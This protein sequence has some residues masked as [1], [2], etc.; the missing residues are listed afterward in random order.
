M[1]SRPKQDA[2]EYQKPLDNTAAEGGEGPP[3]NGN[4]RDRDGALVQTPV[5]V[6]PETRRGTIVADMSGNTLPT[7][8]RRGEGKKKTRA[9]ED[10]EDDA[11]DQDIQDNL[12]AIRKAAAA[13]QMTMKEMGVDMEKKT[14]YNEISTSST[15][16]KEPP[17]HQNVRNESTTESRKNNVPPEAPQSEQGDVTNSSSDTSQHQENRTEGKPKHNTKKKRKSNKRSRKKAEP[18]N[19]SWTEREGTTRRSCNNQRK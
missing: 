6:T 3:L 11:E 10:M 9:T 5:A 19:S 17:N 16:S 18:H 1:P 7:T 13:A 4:K 15:K 14:E 8:S 12:D 2:T